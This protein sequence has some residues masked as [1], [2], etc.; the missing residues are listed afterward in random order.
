VR[1]IQIG[2]QLPVENTDFTVTSSYGV[3]KQI[4]EG[5]LN[6]ATSF[7]NRQLTVEPLRTVYQKPNFA[8]KAIVT[9]NSLL[10]IARQVPTVFVPG[11]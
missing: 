2:T 3:A 9:G 4:F 10:K 6:A 11:I 8:A 1:K 7:I 5:E